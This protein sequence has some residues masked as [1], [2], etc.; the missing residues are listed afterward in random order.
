MADT[1]ASNTDGASAELARVA[2]QLAA[3]LRGR[4][5]TLHASDSADELGS[6]LE[7]VEAFENAVEA[8]GGDLLVDEAPAGK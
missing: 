3:R 7:A 2:E 8:N 5:V 6:L 4:G 1:T